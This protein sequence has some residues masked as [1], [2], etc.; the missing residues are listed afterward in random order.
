M[1]AKLFDRPGF[2]QVLVKLDVCDK[3]RPELR[4]YVQPPEL[5]VCSFA[6]GFSHTCE[7]WAAAERAFERAGETD[8]D[9]AARA[10]YSAVERTESVQ[11]P[12]TALTS[13]PP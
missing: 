2:G 10:L 5:G 4:W 9:S 8:A 12:R 6:F 13:S 11:H 3:G 1:F 7:G